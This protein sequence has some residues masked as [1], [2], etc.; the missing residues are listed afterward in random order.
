MIDRGM[1]VHQLA[2]YPYIPLRFSLSLCSYADV[3]RPSQWPG[4]RADLLLLSVSDPPLQ[5][6]G[7]TAAACSVA[8][9]YAAGLLCCTCCKLIYRPLSRV[10]MHRASATPVYNL[11]QLILR[12]Q[13]HISCRCIRCRVSLSV[14]VGVLLISH[15]I[16]AAHEGQPNRVVRVP[17]NPPTG[18]FHVNCEAAQAAC[19]HSVVACHDVAV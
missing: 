12:C 10:S 2:S 13:L 11:V 16:P 8:T 18:W 6:T 1:H 14:Y 3:S 9:S 17:H 4:L 19:R 7:P 15:V 5:R